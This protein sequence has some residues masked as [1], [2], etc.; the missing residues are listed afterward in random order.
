MRSQPLDH[1]QRELALD[2]S[3]SFI[4]EAPA[5]SGKTELLTQRV[6]TLLSGVSQPEAIL[7]ITFT[8]KAAAE[9]RE[10]ILAALHRAQ[11]EQP[12]EAHAL[13][14]WQLARAVLKR[15]HQLNWGLLHNPNRLQIR[16]FDSLCAFLTQTLPLKA[17]L[18]IN[19]GPTDNPEPLYERAVRSFLSTIEE[20]C[21]WKTALTDVL[22]HL[23]NNQTRL[24]S[25]F[26]S[27][28]KSR[29][30]W[31]P[32]VKQ[33][34]GQH[35]LRAALQGTLQEVL[36]E[37]VSR[38]LDL[39]SPP[40]L[41]SASADAFFELAGYAGA[42][43]Q[44]NNPDENKAELAI[45]ERQ[46]I[47]PGSDERGIRQ[48]RQIKTLLL[49]Q[50]GSFRAKLDKRCGFPSVGTKQEKA[51]FK[52]QKERMTA[53]IEQFQSIPGLQGALQGIDH[54][55]DARYSDI[56][57]PILE[58][59]LELLPVLLA[60]LRLVF[61]QFQEVDFTEMSE[62]A[63]DAL[64]DDEAP[65]DLALRL[66]Q[67][68]EH[69]LVDEF[70]DTSF[71]QVELLARLTA[72]W[73]P[74]DGRTLFCVGDAMQ[75]IYAFRGAKVGLFL[76]CQQYGL[77][78]VSLES[79]KL[80][81]NFRSQ[82]ALVRWINNAF[83]RAFP[84][85]HDIAA[86]AVAFSQADD[87][88]EDLPGPPACTHICDAQ[89]SVEVEKQRIIDVI[90]DT[91]ASDPAA[92]VAILV[93][94]RGHAET[95]VQACQQAAIRFR[96]VDLIP[97]NERQAVQDVLTLCKALLNPMDRIA[98]FATLRAP[99]C[100][101]QLDDLLCLSPENGFAEDTPLI[102]VMQGSVN[103]VAGVRYT[104]SPDGMHRLA[105]VTNVL[106]QALHNRERLPLRQWVEGTW[107]ALG[108][109]DCLTEVADVENVQ[110]V[111]HMLHTLS[112]EG[113]FPSAMELDKALAELFAAPDPLGDERLQI[114]TIHKSKGL[115]FDVVVVPELDRPPRSSGTE[116]LVW[117]ERVG[118]QGH[119]QWILAPIHAT[120]REKDA[121]YHFVQKEKKQRERYETCR[122]L[123]VACTRA[124][125]H[126]HLFARLKRT[127]AGD[128][129]APS[130]GSLLSYI[131][132]TV[133]N[134]N[135]DFGRTDD[136]ALEEGA[137]PGLECV[138]KRLPLT[139]SGPKRV[140]SDLLDAFLI[141][142]QYDN[143]AVGR[144]VLAPEQRSAERIVGSFVHEVL[145]NWVEQGCSEPVSGD[146][147][148][149]V[150]AWRRHLCAMGLT[151][152]EATSRLPTILDGLRK[153]LEHQE[154]RALL[155]RSL[156]CFCE[157]GVATT[158]DKVVRHWVI[159]LL[160]D[161]GQQQAV[162]VDYKTSRPPADV[163]LPAFLEKEAGLYMDVLCQYRA[164]VTGLGYKSVKVVLFFV[165][166]GVWHEVELC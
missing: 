15:D 63:R 5:G 29:D 163:N 118:P 65:T 156:A 110:R 152:G 45:L 124:K 40:N 37:K 157:F 141:D 150:A 115:E 138:L 93:R 145:Q 22:R 81:A 26:I 18:G 21:P 30:G 14:T 113:K 1:K 2:P 76:H 91:W 70:Q 49:T 122:L 101:L 166:I 127:S 56:Q 154:Y 35:E 46:K 111:W 132:D 160:C 92:R 53:V 103:G 74:D 142:E 112:R 133:K 106:G 146:L 139:W 68:I 13:A 149:C 88:R 73:Q 104:L 75:S 158:H 11:G 121:I 47:W 129:A 66:D 25:L 136:N 41:A 135:T 61:A 90:G 67:R 116:L 86:G 114:M 165:M 80:T 126:L 9:M 87:F 27:M 144:L 117:S 97:L 128:W 105:R 83:T 109:A 82:G 28:L 96:A 130:D 151:E 108:G 69:I 89:T 16:T 33:N 164:A 134:D 20:E 102:E 57:W 59:L 43:M 62:R 123:Y 6:L 4:C 71:G 119:E 32:V 23:D 153:A 120:G 51:V 162:I 54:W 85:R 58:S 159:D 42:N 17:S 24:A 55:P 143:T 50:G 107:V 44:R 100:G 125:K 12:G 36:D 7:A 19:V 147:E 140:E 161:V 64:G 98:W 79:I 72:G 99:W 52:A 78:D 137:K 31:I 48:W 148:G 94:N 60:H 39:L 3:R 84:M 8:R 95:A 10:R 155:S 77:G 34:L 38:L 131:W